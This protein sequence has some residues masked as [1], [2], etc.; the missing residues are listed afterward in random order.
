MPGLA[1][2]RASRSGGKIYDADVEFPPMKIY[3]PKSKLPTIRS[4]I[5]MLRYHVGKGGAG[6]SVDI[7]VR[8]VAKQVMAK[9]YHDTVCCKSLSTITR[10]VEKLRSTF[11]NGKRRFTARGEKSL[12]EA[13]V[14]KYLELFDIK[15]SLFDIY[16]E[17]KDKRMQVEAE[18]GVTM[19]PMEYQY[20][21][22]Q[23]S[24]RKMECTKG[25]DPVWYHAMMR[26]QRMR[27]RLEEYK[28]QR[29]KQFEYASLDRIT[30]LLDE[31][32]KVV[33][34]DQDIENNDPQNIETVQMLS[35]GGGT[36]DQEQMVSGGD[37]VQEL[38]AESDQVL[39][40][41]DNA[42]RRKRKY[43]DSVQGIEEDPLPVKYRSIRVSERKVRD[44][45]SRLLPIFLVMACL[46]RRLVMLLLMWAMDYLVENGRREL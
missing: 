22:D 17:D 35:S 46:W 24:E 28:E 8:E 1:S 23:K 10:E 32:G 43:A 39:V 36:S 41:S 42:G 4:V 40:E 18:W 27:E 9:W 37:D 5:G 31:N 44:E 13:V 3:E 25:V 7:A 38:L 2:G 34:S 16:Q 29:E 12:N 6:K 11:V 30:E 21:E 33:W 15:S 20:Y 26:R 45:V 19:S 14:K